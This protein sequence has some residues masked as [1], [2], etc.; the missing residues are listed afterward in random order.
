[1]QIP[2]LHFCSPM[3]RRNVQAPVQAQDIPRTL[4]PASSYL[5]SQTQQVVQVQDVVGVH[6]ATLCDTRTQ[7]RAEIVEVGCHTK[8]QAG[9]ILQGGRGGGGECQHLRASTIL[10]GGREGTEKGQL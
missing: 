7:R 3:T 4:P 10:E 2:Q 1:M 8:Q 6:A 5:C 9:S